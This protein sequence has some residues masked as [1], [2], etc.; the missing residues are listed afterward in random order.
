[1]AFY[2]K[3]FPEII[4]AGK[5]YIAEPPLYRINDKKDPFVI[6]TA[7]YINRYVNLASKNYKLGYQMTKDELDVRWLNK[8]QWFKFLGDTSKYV[9]TMRSLVD[10]YKVNDRLLELIFEEFAM[11]GDETP[12]NVIDKLNIQHMM[13]C[14]GAEF[15]ELY[16]DDENNLIKGSID[17]K[18]QMIEISESLVKKGR[19]II[20]IMVE[21]LPPENGSIVLRDT[22]TGMESR[23]SLLKTL[24]ILK[25]YQPDILHRFKG[26]TN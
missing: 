16:Y 19:D 20:K 8:D 24:K 3:I 10:R 22:K 26:L 23:L 21:W 9:D 13:N 15:K 6:N 14:I 18:W 12:Y 7:D 11:F 5:L 1:M 2:F 17:A 25:K 4:E